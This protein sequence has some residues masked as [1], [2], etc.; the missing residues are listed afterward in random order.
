[1]VGATQP[2]TPGSKEVEG[3]RGQSAWPGKGLRK[4]EKDGEGGA[5]VGVNG[6]IKIKQIY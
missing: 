4:E 3:L 2:L 6:L 5:A 1:M